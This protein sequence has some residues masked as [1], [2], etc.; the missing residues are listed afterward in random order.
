MATTATPNTAIPTFENAYEQVKESS[1]QFLAAARKA[2]NLYLDSYEK[3]VDRTA[4]LQLKLAGLSQQEWLKSLIE[5][6]VDVSKELASSY[7]ATARS[8]LK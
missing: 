7:T 4:E 1:E 8:F 2:G 5:A 6:Q 3:A